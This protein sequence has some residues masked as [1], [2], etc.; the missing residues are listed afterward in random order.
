MLPLLRWLLIFSAIFALLPALPLILA[1]ITLAGFLSF[2]FLSDI[3]CAAAGQL[4]RL[5]RLRYYAFLMLPA[6][7]PPLSF[8]L[9]L[10]CR[11][12][13]FAEGFIRAADPDMP[14]TL[15]NFFAIF[16]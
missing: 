3:D 13:S 7:F 16:A 15:L 5:S 12:F 2:C 14:D 9:R 8:L 4:P 10:R 11:W 6:S 1:A